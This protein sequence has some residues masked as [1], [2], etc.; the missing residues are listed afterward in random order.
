[1]ILMEKAQIA[2]GSRVFLLRV[3]E[4]PFGFPVH[5]YGHPCCRGKRKALPALKQGELVVMPGCG[6]A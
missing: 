4:N 3:R 5:F 2:M 6:T 1:M